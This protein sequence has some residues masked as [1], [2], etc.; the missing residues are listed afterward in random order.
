MLAAIDEARTARTLRT[1]VLSG[2][3][4]SLEPPILTAA[5]PGL[6]LS[7]VASKRFSLPPETLFAAG[8]C[9]PG[10]RSPQHHTCYS[11]VQVPAILRQADTHTPNSRNRHRRAFPLVGVRQLGVS[12]KLVSVAYSDV[13][14]LVISSAPKKLRVPYPAQGSSWRPLLYEHIEIP[15]FVSVSV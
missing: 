14:S 8:R 6:T 1:G 13:S 2:P 5:V 11:T 9:N 15:G 12:D 10:G 3:T 4:A 7:V